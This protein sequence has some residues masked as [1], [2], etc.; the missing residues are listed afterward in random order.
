MPH[1]SSLMVSM[2]SERKRRFPRRRNCV[3]RHPRPP[4]GP[5]PFC[6]SLSRT[7]RQVVRQGI[8]ALQPCQ[9]PACYTTAWSSPWAHARPLRSR[10][11]PCRASYCSGGSDLRVLFMHGLESGTTGDK[12]M[13]LREHFRTVAVPDMQVSKYR[14][15]RRNSLP[16]C[17]ARAVCSFKAWPSQWLA[18]AITDSLSDCLQRQSVAIE[19]PPGAPPQNECGR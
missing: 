7:M 5:T 8:H 17:Y 10:T 19:V 13:Y 4:P 15:D 14:L 3:F 1:A 16:R 12:A 9:A 11:R 6:S 2:G 18:A